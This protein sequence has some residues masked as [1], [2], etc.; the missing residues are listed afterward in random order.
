[1]T[2]RGAAFLLGLGCVVAF[3][4]CVGIWRKSKELAAENR[5]LRAEVVRLEADVK[6]AAPVQ[7]D[8]ARAAEFEAQKRELLR[9]RN[10]VA[11]LRANRDVMIQ[12]GEELARARA[13]QRSA[14]APAVVST[15]AER[16][17]REDWKFGGFETPEAALVSGM[18]AMREGQVQSLLATFTL[19]ERQRF[20]EQMQGKSE[21]EIALRFQKEF[22]KVTGMRVV[23]QHETTP[24]EVV[25]DVYLEGVGKL[26]KYRMNQ[27]NNEWKAGGPVDQNLNVAQSPENTVDPMAYYMRNPELMKRYFPQLYQKLQQQQQQQAAGVQPAVAP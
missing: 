22:G 5:A 2:I 7:P 14:A 25:L 6:A 1:M 16:L 10:E 24:R 20:E 13:N 27:V 19:E 18:W 4:V 21:A 15:N 26:K 9:L 17:A 12:R 23:G 3:V 11:Q 8:A